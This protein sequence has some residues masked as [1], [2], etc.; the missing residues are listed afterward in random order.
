MTIDGLHRPNPGSRPVRALVAATAVLLFS[1]CGES[2]IG[3]AIPPEISLSGSYSSELKLSNCTFGG[4]VKCDVTNIS[5][6]TLR[7]REAMVTCLDARGAV[8]GDH[9]YP[10]R[11]NFEPGQTYRAEWVAECGST[12]DISSKAHQ[13]LVSVAAE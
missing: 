13:I 2:D 12:P 9:R 7:R 11:D 6:R 1:G 3:Q 8:L 10:R 5:S 4:M